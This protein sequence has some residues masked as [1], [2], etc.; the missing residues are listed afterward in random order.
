MLARSSGKGGDVSSRWAA[1]SVFVGIVQVA[2]VN[3]A[4]L[5]GHAVVDGQAAATG[6]FSVFY[7]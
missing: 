6:L 5:R 7:G 3:P 2:E 1:S 4:R